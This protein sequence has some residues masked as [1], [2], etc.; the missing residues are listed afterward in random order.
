MYY[1][2]MKKPDI[3]NSSSVHTVAKPIGTLV[4]YTPEYCDQVVTLVESIQLSTE[5]VY[6]SK[7]ILE[8]YYAAGRKGI[9]TWLW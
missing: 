1:K 2:R 8:F 9:A 5:G 4:P 3:I 6:P 7:N